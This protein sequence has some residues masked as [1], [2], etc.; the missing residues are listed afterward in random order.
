MMAHFEQNVQ[1]KQQRKTPTKHVAGDPG[2][3]NEFLRYPNAIKFYR[4]LQLRIEIGTHI[5]LNNKIRIFRKRRLVR[6]ALAAGIIWHQT[7]CRLHLQFHLL[8]S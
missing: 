6:G 3:Q 5:A 8:N 2:T 4:E 1:D 7:L